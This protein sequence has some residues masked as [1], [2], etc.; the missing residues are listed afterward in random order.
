MLAE[1][2]TCIHTPDDSFSIFT[3]AS[4]LREKEGEIRGR[5]DGLFKSSTNKQKKR[6]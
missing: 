3:C 2:P 1:S 5:R 6:P 4:F